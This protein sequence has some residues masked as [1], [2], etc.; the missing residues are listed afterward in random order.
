MGRIMRPK[1]NPFNEFNAFFYTLV[2]LDTDE[3]SFCKQ[4]QKILID[5]GFQHEIKMGSQLDYSGM[6][7]HDLDEKEHLLY[8]LSQHQEGDIMLSRGHLNDQ[9]EGTRVIE[10]GL[11]IDNDYC[12][13]E[14]ED[15]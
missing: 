10:R 12:Y 1:D 3:V 13:E 7:L 9:R 6:K 8:V 4:R 14:M 5:Q 11:G 15:E 2:S